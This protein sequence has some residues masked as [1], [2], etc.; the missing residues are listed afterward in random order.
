MFDLTGKVAVVTGSSRGI[1][2]AIALLL[3]KQGAKVVVNSSKSS[4]AAEDVVKEIKANGGEAVNVAADVSNQADAERLIKTAVDS[5]GRLDIL[6]NNAGVTR[7][8]LLMRMSEADWD[9]VMDLN[10][11]GAF[12]CTKAA[13][14]PMLKAKS[15]RIINITS[16][17]GLAGNAGQ[18]N[19]AASKA[20]LVGFTKSVARELASRAIT[21]NA[22][23]PGFVPTVL[24][25]VLPDDLKA[26]AIAAI[27]LA[28]VGSPEEIAAAVVYLASDEAAYVT[29]H[30]LTV[31]GGMTMM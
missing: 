14:R 26:K 15:G 17:S 30:V 18:A 11:K 3:A 23:A 28:R 2:R 20:G 22:V 10:L 8:T 16:V 19:Y 5:F 4:A 13:I 21:C 31:D 27:P 25:N 7:D 12:F 1:G 24:T 9:A 6:V 29:G